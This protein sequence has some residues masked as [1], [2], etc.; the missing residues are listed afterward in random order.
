[1]IAQL[2]ISFV[3]PVVLSLMI[4]PLVIRFANKIG[5]MD[6]PGARKVHTSV[7][8]RLGGLAIFASIWLSALI[9]LSIFPGLFDG[10]R[11]DAVPSYIVMTALVCIFAL[12]F[13]DDLRTLKPGIKFG[14]QFVIAALVY[15]AGF[16]ISNVTN[17]LDGSVINVELLDFPL[18]LLWIVGITNAFNLIDGLDGLASGVAAIA[19]ASI[20]T[21]S[22]VAG[23]I[24]SAVLA[25]ILAGAL[26]GFL[27]YN[28]NPAKIFLGDSG[29]LV[30][31]FCLALMSMQSTTKLST[32]FALLFPMLV[33]ILPITD[34]LISM[35]RRFFG[36]YLSEQ[37]GEK[38]ESLVH[39][40]HG[41]F[42]PDKS[43]IHHQLLSLGLTHRNTVL[44][45]YVVSAFFAAGAFA[46][47]QIDSIEKSVSMAVLFGFVLFTGIKKLRYHEIAI[48]NNGLMLPL[49]E[50]WILNRTIFLRLI[51]FSFI[52]ASYTLSYYLIQTNTGF[53][54]ANFDQ[55]LILISTVQLS[56]FWFTGLY[57]E[58]INPLGIG[59]VLNITASVA[60]A[61]AGAAVIV[62]VSGTFRGAVIIRF[63]IFDFYFLLTLTLG[64]R[65]AYQA[66]VYWFNR[67]KKSGE[68]VLIYGANENGTM[69][70]HKINN[71]SE[72][73][74]KIVGFLDDDPE[75]EGKLI[76]GYPILGGHWKLS[77]TLLNKK[78]DSILI[79]EQ[80]I[81][82]E[83]FKRLKRIADEKGIKVKYLQIRLK[84]I[85][86]SSADRIESATLAEPEVTNI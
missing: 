41:M 58:K 77:R 25:L 44:L 12:G 16:R 42:I 26:T 63:L 35:A 46:I 76:N 37:T 4:T 68:T 29:S 19:S 67:D 22:I 38:N 15:Y 69:I 79:C 51:D 50:R 82:P 24:W 78:V 20:F 40:L 14:V 21:V 13:I 72:S 1:M 70:L 43:H 11:D 84:N 31:G 9:L 48:F 59:N 65:I 56:I 33:L 75:L 86:T 23:E 53:E 47:T 32:G 10:I 55:S 73:K 5:A 66:L 3:I 83:N 45:L 71:S 81:K 18:T 6:A 2:V 80:H 17:P 52:A 49:Y 7:T 54:Y 57:R 60:Y 39:K 27:R 8:P 85:R 61:V 62:L 36:S 64:V 28:F 30:I 34:T 74:Y